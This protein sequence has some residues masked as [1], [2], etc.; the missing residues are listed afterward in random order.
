MKDN[1]GFKI[2]LRD[3]TIPNPHKV[4]GTGV[5]DTC[6]K[7]PSSPRKASALRSNHVRSY[8]SASCPVTD[9][10]SS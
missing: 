2:M 10:P 4:I 9:F 7:S 1:L 8:F 6:G 3:E 5:R